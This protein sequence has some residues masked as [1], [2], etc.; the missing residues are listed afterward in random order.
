MPR[1][2]R[3]WTQQEDQ[4]LF[5][6]VSLQHRETGKHVDWNIIAQSFSDR[7]NKDCRKRWLKIDQRW[8]RGNW[9]PDEDELLQKAVKYH[10][11]RWSLVSETVGRRNPDQCSRR[12]H[13]FFDPRVEHGAWSESED[14]RLDAAVWEHG[15]DWKYIATH[16]FPHRSR[17]IL[18][19]RF[20]VISRR[21][22]RLDRSSTM[23]QGS[24]VNGCDL[25]SFPPAEQHTSPSST[26]SAEDESGSGYIHPGW[27]SA[28]SI[29][30]FDIAELGQNLLTPDMEMFLDEHALPQIENTQLNID[31][32]P[33]GSTHSDTCLNLMGNLPE[34]ITKDPGFPSC[35]FQV[36]DG[37][38]T[39]Q[40]VVTTLTLENVNSQTRSEILDIL[41]KARVPTTIRIG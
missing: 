12:W 33:I 23:P 28:E 27:D 21:K 36:R 19:N 1:T 38:G 13:D 32:A 16:Y 18:N 40:S 34:D 26:N 4:N 3:K 22:E 24:G 29:I 25:L 7:T 5:L 41:M 2:P 14:A 11:K 39:S 35:N 31:E 17:T 20:S 10:G 9:E 30:G 37:Q 6:G 15:R 8:H